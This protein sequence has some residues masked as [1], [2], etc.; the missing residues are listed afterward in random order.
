MLLPVGLPLT[1][2]TGTVAVKFKASFGWIEIDRN[3]LRLRAVTL[4]NLH[5]LS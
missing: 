2:H 1:I 4:G 3:I 5:R